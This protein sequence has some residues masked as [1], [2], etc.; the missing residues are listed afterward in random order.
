MIKKKGLDKKKLLL[1]NIKN[2]L[3]HFTLSNRLLFYKTLKN[4]FQYKQNI[5]TTILKKL[6]KLW[7]NLELG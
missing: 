6:S 2:M 7:R 3:K 1:K 5:Y 4:N